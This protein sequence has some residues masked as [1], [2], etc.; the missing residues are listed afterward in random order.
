MLCLPVVVRLDDGKAF[1][2]D[3]ELTGTF[4]FTVVLDMISGKD[5]SSS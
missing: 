4:L 3:T 2:V 5:R 1:C